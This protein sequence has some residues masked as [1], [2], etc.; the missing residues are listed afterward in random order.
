MGG[1][2][3]KEPTPPVPRPPM[4]KLPDYFPTYEPQCADVAKTFFTCFETTA[5]I[6]TPEDVARGKQALELCQEQLLAYAVCMEKHHRRDNK[7]WWSRT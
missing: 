2:Q 6:R 4:T 1:K 3:T 7:N 5:K